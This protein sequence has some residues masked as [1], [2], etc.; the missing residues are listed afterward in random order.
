MSQIIRYYWPEAA[1][2]GVKIHWQTDVENLGMNIFRYEVIGFADCI[3]IEVENVPEN[4]PSRMTVSTPI[5]GEK[6]FS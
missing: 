5:E 3:L 4:L 2:N 1:A 6:I